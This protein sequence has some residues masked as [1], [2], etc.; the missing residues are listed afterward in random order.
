MLRRKP[1][2]KS[3]KPLKNNGKMFRYRQKRR[4]QWV[5]DH[6]PNHEGYYE[7]WICRK[8]VPA[9]EMA[10]DHVLPKSSTPRLIA[11]HDDNLRPA[12]GTCNGEKGSKRL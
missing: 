2:K 8:W 7:C 10:L 1:L 3:Q 5:T 9:D 11:E 12:H 6:P 4:A